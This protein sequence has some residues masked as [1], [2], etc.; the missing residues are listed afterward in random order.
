MTSTE[1]FPEQLFSKRDAAQSRNDLTNR[2]HT[3]M[4]VIADSQQFGLKA[5]EQ[6]AHTAIQTEIARAPEELHSIPQVQFYLAD[7]ALA[8]S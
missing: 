8:E 7:I 6:S 1:L 4:C 3:L 2:I 5:F